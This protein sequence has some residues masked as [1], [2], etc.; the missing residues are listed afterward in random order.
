MQ[1]RCQSFSRQPATVTSRRVSA[2]RRHVAPTGSASCNIVLR[3]RSV[4]QCR[5]RVALPE[6]G[7]RSLHAAL[8]PECGT[9]RRTNRRKTHGRR[10]IRCG[11]GAPSPAQVRTSAG[12]ILARVW[13]LHDALRRRE[14]ALCA[15]TEALSTT[16]GRCGESQGWPHLKRT[17]KGIRSRTERASHND[18]APQAIIRA[19]ETLEAACGS[20]PEQRMCA[21]TSTSYTTSTPTV[22]L[23]AAIRCPHARRSERA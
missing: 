6:P 15:T 1:G 8:R 23:P 7:P 4:A 10:P 2:T 11:R 9:Q 3:R 14:P 12:P 16:P 22:R 20:C 5:S 13:L 19:L 17:A 21:P 18:R